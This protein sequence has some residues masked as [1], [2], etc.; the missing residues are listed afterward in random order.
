MEKVV[1]GLDRTLDG[2]GSCQSLEQTLGL[3]LIIHNIFAQLKLTENLIFVE[4]NEFL[5]LPV[6]LLESRPPGVGHRPPWQS[7]SSRSSSSTSG[8]LKVTRNTNQLPSHQILFTSAAESGI[9][10]QNF[11]HNLKKT[12][13]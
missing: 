9:V 4:K 8:I 1:I 10:L 7:W 2:T 11:G 13:P 6:R 3:I 12:V 5:I